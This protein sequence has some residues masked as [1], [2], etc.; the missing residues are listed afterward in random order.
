MAEFHRVVVTGMGC[1]SP[2]GPDVES[3]WQ[4]VIDGHSAFSKIDQTIL[5]GFD[6]LGTSVAAT[7]NDF[8]LD[9]DPDLAA[10]I[11][12]KE[13]RT[14]HRSAQFALF[15]GAQALR[16]AGVFTNQFTPD[17]QKFIN[18]DLVNPDYFGAYIGTGIGGGDVLG[19]DQ[20]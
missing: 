7:I 8:S 4:Q 1:V 18:R 2:L 17:W 3:S 9:L 19:P 6:K 12:P 13:L 16:Q 10:A 15:A 11:D 20:S 14:L 5:A